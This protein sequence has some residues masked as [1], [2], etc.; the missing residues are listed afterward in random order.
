MQTF[1]GCRP[2]GVCVG[3]VLSGERITRDPKARRRLGVNPKRL[4]LRLS[5][6]TELPNSGLQPDKGPER[7]C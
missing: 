4:V 5:I 6:R 2:G 1:G 3:G 7:L